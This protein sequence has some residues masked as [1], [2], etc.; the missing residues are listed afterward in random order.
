MIEAEEQG[1]SGAVA[2]VVGVEVFLEYYE[3]EKKLH[4]AIEVYVEKAWVMER[5]NWLE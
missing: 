2:L 4:Q 1:C 5:W 3:A